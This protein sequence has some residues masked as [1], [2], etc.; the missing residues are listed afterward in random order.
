MSQNFWI[1]EYLRPAFVSDAAW[2]KVRDHLFLEISDPL[3]GVPDYLT[4]T[5]TRLESMGFT[6][7]TMLTALKFQ[8]EQILDLGSLQERTNIGSLGQGWS[9]LADVRLQISETGAKTISG[10]VSIDALY[11]LNASASAQYIA[12]VSLGKVV[13]QDGSMTKDGVMLRPVFTSSNTSSNG[14]SLITT[15]AGY[16]AI[17]SSGDK[18]VFDADGKF[19]SFVTNQGHEIDVIYDLEGR[20][21]R[22]EN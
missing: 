17:A 15:L 12:S 22:Y 4:D 3:E 6:N 9:S 18:F 20:I 16:E 7:V 21:A 13:G 10:L 8:V 11:S 19:L 1:E 2:Q 5:I 14:F